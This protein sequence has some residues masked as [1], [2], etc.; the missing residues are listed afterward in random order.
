[1]SL[2]NDALR[3]K[4]RET[5]VSPVETGF[6]D[7]SQRPRITRRW[8]VGLAGMILLTIATF[9][10]THLMKSSTGNSLL[11]KSPQPDR[12]QPAA[13]HPTDTTPD[14][15]HRSDATLLP[16]PADRQTETIKSEDAPK[17]NHRVSAGLEPAPP[18]S[19]VNGKMPDS[20]E[21]VSAS[22]LQPAD[23]QPVFLSVSKAS[24]SI[25]TPAESSP[26]ELKAV[27]RAFEPGPVQTN[28]VEKTRPVT[29]RQLQSPTQLAPSPAPGARSETIGGRNADAAVRKTAPSNGNDDLFY[30]K[31][32]AYH[33]SGR[34]ADA[35]RIYRQVLNTNSSHPGAMLNLS[36]AYMQQGNYV[37]AHTLLKR[38]EQSS[39]RPQGVLLNL[40]IAAIGMGAP[41]RALDDLDRATALS[42][43]SP[44]EI[45]FHRA[46]AFA[47]MNRLPEALVLY[48]EAA[49][50]QP[51]DPRLQF[52]LAV[53]CDALGLYPEAITHY[54]AVLR[55]TSEP[56]E[57]DKESIILRIRTI[58]R[59]LDTAQ[60]SARGQ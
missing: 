54:E 57:T 44:W 1:M 37:E 43:A 7:G 9:Y 41:E 40:A 30:K 47:R 31:A 24:R 52:N 53:T 34:L 32:R 59:Y 5:T 18:S 39:P 21:G 48:R 13:N 16:A 33:R 38:L 27:S 3:K 22:D 4:N 35:I 58:G 46:V 50:E 8:L 55:A 15:Q 51:D 6:I 12:S 26:R 49:A 56:A 28:A 29:P 42:D 25:R 11:A 23:E 36:A 14:V 17:G 10:G 45:R 20:R 60:S 19:T 2:M